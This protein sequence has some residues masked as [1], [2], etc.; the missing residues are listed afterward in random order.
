MF[1][2]SRTAYAALLTA[3]QQLVAALTHN[4]QASA[5]LSLALA[6]HASLLDGQN[7]AIASTA[8]SV[9]YLARAEKH[10]RESAGHPSNF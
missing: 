5:A 2:K 6:N 10:R 4:S 3:I 8:E 1:K 9:R 7:P